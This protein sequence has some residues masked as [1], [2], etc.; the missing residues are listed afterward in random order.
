MKIDI[1]NGQYFY[2]LFYQISFLLV[3]IIY[4]IEGHKR[5]FPWS[6]WLLVIV[7]VRIFFIIGSKFGAIT[8]E[9]F[10]YFAENLR[11]PALYNTNLIGALI[12]GFI[13]VGIAK[14]LLR[15]RYPILDAFA[16]AAPF[17]MAV[18]R[19]GCLMVGCCYGTETH[20]P[21]GIKY[22]VDSPAFVHQFFTHQIG[23][24]DVLSQSIHPVPLYFIISCLLTGIVLILLRHYWKRPGNLTLFGLMLLLVSRFLIEFFRDPESNG[25]FQGN[26]FLG[27]KLVQLFS[28]VA[29]ITLLVVIR[30]R[31]KQQTTKTFIVQ[32]NHPLH[33][34]Y[35]LLMLS[36]LLF[37]T[38]NWFSEIELNVLFFALVP[39]CLLVSVSL[40]KNYYSLRVKISTISLM[41]LSL[42]LM[43]QKIPKGD[44][45][46]TKNI[47]FGFS[48][49]DYTNNHNIGHGEG[50]SRV[51]NSQSF[52][53]KFSLGGLGYSIVKK[54]SLKVLEYG[55]NG[56]F[57]TRSETGLITGAK[58]NDPVLG[59]NPFVKISNNWFGGGIG[60]H[61]GNLKL[62]PYYWR[63][64]NNIASMPQTGT[65][66]TFIYPLVYAR[67]GPEKILSL[68][69][70]LGDHFPAPFPAFYEYLE[71]GS[72]FGSNNFRLNL[73]LNFM[74]AFI[75][76]A[77]VPIGDRFILEPL[78]QWNNGLIPDFNEDYQF[79]VGLHYLLSSSN[80][81]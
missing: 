11:F 43:S 60:L 63:E 54:D 41:L 75:L 47:R 58:N 66:N 21:W 22:G 37:T 78:Y 34:A 77:K 20:L 44:T 8:S 52:K 2:D 59:I 35:Y 67:I 79:S 71:L 55:V 49:G 18:Q 28:L 24:Q 74:G 56:Y 19:I 80:T 53:Q 1:A 25:S 69:Y 15:I 73:G 26:Y 29:V 50:C 14:I 39:A 72:G 7:T 13:G 4:L 45:I 6:T 81:R 32:A 65:Q 57:G 42:V 33:N 3:L 61:L 10:R 31:E 40:I 51:S 70:H 30:I 48:N 76:K 38:K 46:S 12:F 68:S 5:K 17:G 62:T 16:I 36:V 23:M 27:L 64:E 9:D